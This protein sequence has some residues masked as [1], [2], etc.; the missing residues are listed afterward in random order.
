MVICDVPPDYITQQMFIWVIGLL[1]TLN[2]GCYTF[3]F[4][5]SKQ[6]NQN[7]ADLSEIKGWRDK[8][9]NDLSEEKRAQVLE[10]NVLSKEFQSGQNRIYDK[11]DD[12]AK[13]HDAKLKSIEDK[14]TA[15]PVDCARHDERIKRL[16][17]I[18]S[19]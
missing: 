8:T 10:R 16:E 13:D 17:E 1:T 11:L 12:I 9:Q 6:V 2:A 15:I 19:Q 14:V 5:V 4:L 3:V 18:I 7:A